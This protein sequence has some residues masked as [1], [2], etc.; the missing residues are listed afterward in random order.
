M[1]MARS[2][3]ETCSPVASSMSTSR[4]GGEGVTSWASRSR[5]S[6]V[7]PMAETTTTAPWPAFTVSTT[8]RATPRIFRASATED[9][10]YFWT[11]RPMGGSSRGSC[12]RSRA[13]AFKVRGEI[14]V[15]GRSAPTC[16]GARLPRVSG[17]DPQA[18]GR[19]RH[20]AEAIDLGQ[21]RGHVPLDG[22]VREHHDGHGARPALLD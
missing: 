5:V 16:P 11:I 3:M 19:Q 20:D 21:R 8:R 15:P 1:A 14:L 18:D 6:V 13:R 22:L 10:P 7:L 17:L 4:S 12:Y 2:A 9:P